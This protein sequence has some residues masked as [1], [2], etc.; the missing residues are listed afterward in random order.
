MLESEIH[1][2]CTPGVD[3][4]AKPTDFHSRFSWTL[5]T[6]MFIPFVSKSVGFVGPFYDLVAFYIA[7]MWF[8]WT[9][10]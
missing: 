6:I 3:N 1:F 9:V 2:K 7:I 10:P 8:S 5:S 4:P